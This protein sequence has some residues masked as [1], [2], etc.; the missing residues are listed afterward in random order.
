MRFG[1][2]GRRI[3]YSEQFLKY[4]IHEIHHLIEQQYL[5]SR[6]LSNRNLTLLTEH[7]H[8]LIHWY[9]SDCKKKFGDTKTVYLNPTIHTVSIGHVKT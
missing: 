6:G 1:K 7:W 4:K 3:T 5:N 2:E 9:L 8:K